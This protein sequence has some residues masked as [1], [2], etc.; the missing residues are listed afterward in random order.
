VSDTGPGIR[1]EDMPRLFQEF[2]QVD[3]ST[4]RRSGGTGL[5]L[6]LCKS[7]IE[8]HGGT[9]GAEAVPGHGSTFWMMLPEDGPVRLGTAYATPSPAESAAP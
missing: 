6:V 8:L 1:P 2:S 5:G 3:S 7:F 9:I 4:S